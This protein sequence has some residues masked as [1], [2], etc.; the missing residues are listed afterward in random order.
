MD[1]SRHPVF[2]RIERSRIRKILN[3]AEFKETGEN[4]FVDDL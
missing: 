4:A 1:Q 3:E 2:V